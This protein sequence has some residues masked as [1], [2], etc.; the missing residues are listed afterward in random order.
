MSLMFNTQV[1]R[2]LSN[3]L[4]PLL[5]HMLCPQ[6]QL[7]FYGFVPWSIIQ[8]ITLPLC[9]FHRFHSAVTLAEIWKTTYKARLE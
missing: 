6:V 7:E 3:L 5:L 9:I 8:R 4:T 2:Y 1:A